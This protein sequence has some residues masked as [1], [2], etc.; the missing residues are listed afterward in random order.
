MNF[1]T[2]LFIRGSSCILLPCVHV[3]PSHSYFSLDSCRSWVYSTRVNNRIELG[4]F[5]SPFQ[6]TG[7]LK[8]HRPQLSCR[9][10][11]LFVSAVCIIVYDIIGHLFTFDYRFSWNFIKFF[12]VCLPWAVTIDARL[13][14][15]S[16]TFWYHTSVYLITFAGLLTSEINGQWDPD[17]Q[18]PTSVRGSFIL[19]RY[20][21]I[22]HEHQASFLRRWCVSSVISVKL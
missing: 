12:F 7:D 16:Y 1:K 14:N 2:C 15:N 22:T 13:N 3:G 20:M 21:W 17:A 8:R 11:L 9:Q 5:S 18:C 19:I 4:F 10:I 6:T